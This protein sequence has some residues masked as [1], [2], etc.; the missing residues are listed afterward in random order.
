MM[1]K[2]AFSITAAATMIA[3]VVVPATAATNSFTLDITATVDNYCR[4]NTTPV[5]FGKYDP[6]DSNARYATGTLALTCTKG[7][8]PTTIRLDYGKN[9][10]G[11]T[12][13]TMMST[14][15]SVADKLIYELYKPAADN[16]CSVSNTTIWG[17]TVNDGLSITGITAGITAPVVYNVCGKI[18]AGQDV[19]PSTYSDVVTAY[20]DF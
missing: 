14:S 16:S 19:A 1:K 10:N 5:N 9:A 4:L 15:A 7:T 20:V 12:T 2:F 18:A 8:A 11:G 13:R 3:A 6:T 17:D